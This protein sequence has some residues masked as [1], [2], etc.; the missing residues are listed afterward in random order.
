MGFVKTVKKFLK[1]VQVHEQ[2]TA[3]NTTRNT[4]PITFLE[5]SKIHTKEWIKNE[6]EDSDIKY[7]F[8]IYC[9]LELKEKKQKEKAYKELKQEELNA[10]VDEKW[11]EFKNSRDYKK[12]VDQLIVRQCLQN[13]GFL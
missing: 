11:D 6:K 3:P 13:D 7:G 8:F 4:A 1:S 12:F 5:F 9:H 10:L 2:N